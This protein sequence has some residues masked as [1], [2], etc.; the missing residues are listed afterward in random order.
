MDRPS[1]MFSPQQDANP[2]G[3]AGPLGHCTAIHG[4]W[5]QGLP[6]L[7]APVVRYLKAPERLLKNRLHRPAS[8]R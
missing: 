4:F 7:S 1:Y 8:I 2:L 3:W 5:L 6:S